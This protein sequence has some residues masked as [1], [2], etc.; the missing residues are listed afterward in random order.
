MRFDLRFSARK[1]HPCVP[2]EIVQECR[3]AQALAAIVPEPEPEIVPPPPPVPPPPKPVSSDI[4]IVSITLGLCGIG[5]MTYVGYQVQQCTS[6]KVEVTRKQKRVKEVKVMSSQ[7]EAAVL[8]AK[9]TDARD[10]SQAGKN[11]V[12]AGKGK[13]D[14]IKMSYAHAENMTVKAGNVFEGVSN[15]GKDA[16]SELPQQRSALQF[17]AAAAGLGNS[18]QEGSPVESHM[19]PRM[20]KKDLITEVRPSD[21]GLLFSTLACALAYPQS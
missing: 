20:R 13:N 5:A 11:L 21:H 8:A 19:I 7:K 9:M 2:Q 14:G 3:I 10:L 12:I 6:K 15:D 4:V 17:G 1:R 16:W 18:Y